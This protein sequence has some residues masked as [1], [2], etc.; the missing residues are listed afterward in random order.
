MVPLPMRSRMVPVRADCQMSFILP[1]GTLRV[2]SIQPVASD[3]AW[4]RVART[5]PR[6]E[7]VPPRTWME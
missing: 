4:Y 7:H 2:V 1:S 3:L 5:T 6:L